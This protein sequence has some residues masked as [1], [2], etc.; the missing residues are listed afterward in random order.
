MNMLVKFPTRSRPE[1]FTEV[2]TAACKLLSGEHE[3]RWLVSIDDDDESMQNHPMR[4]DPPAGVEFI[5]GPRTTKVGACNAG[6]PGPWNWDVLVL[7]SDDMVPQ[8]KSWDA[9]ICADLVHSFYDLDG[10]LWYDDGFVGEKLDTLPIMG[11]PYYDRF[12][13]VYEP[14]YQSVWCDN[15]FTDVGKLLGR[16]PYSSMCLFRHEHPANIGGNQDQLYL[17]NGGMDLWNVDHARYDFRL[18]SK[19]GVRLLDILICTIPTRKDLLANVVQNLESQIKKA[20]LEQNVGIIVEADNCRLTI[21]EKRNLLVARS[22]AEYVCHVDDDDDVSSNY[23]KSIIWAIGNCDVDAVGI[24]GSIRLGSATKEN[25]RP[26]IH[27]IKYDRFYQTPDNTYVRPPNHLNPIRR[28][29][30]NRYPF[31]TISHGEDTDF[32][33]R[34]CRTY[35]L[36]TERMAS[37]SPIYLYTPSL[38]WAQR[39]GRRD[40]H[41]SV[42]LANP[43]SF[44]MLEQDMRADSLPPVETEEARKRGEARPT[45]PVFGSVPEPP[46]AAAPAVTSTAAPAPALAPAPVTLPPPTVLIPVPPPAIPANVSTSQWRAEGAVW[47]KKYGK[48][49]P[50]R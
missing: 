12:G 9:I 30:V 18:S 42:N 35:A 27:S 7:L 15:E 4:L 20:R 47:K 17:E 22:K 21:G 28:K 26:F 25:W 2:Y 50:R 24:I 16:L 13:Y 44:P 48:K 43:A 23:V 14:G 10:A 40:G 1:K 49:P 41:A 37:T 19:F 46:Q 39:R 36:K 6:L 29:I 8:V 5:S 3:V 34:M 32:A 45:D 38:W 33:L 11:R 31:K